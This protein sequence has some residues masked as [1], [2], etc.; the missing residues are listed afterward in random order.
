MCGIVGYI[1]SSPSQT[2]RIFYMLE[3]IK[4]RGPDDDGAVL[5]NLD[6]DAESKQH[7]FD[8]TNP[9]AFAKEYRQSCP[10]HNVALGHVRYSIVDL[11]SLG[12]QPMW[13]NC[14][15]Y[16]ISFNGEIYN[17][18]ELREELIRLG[19]IF[20][21]LTD[22]EV[23]LQAY[24]QWGPSF[25]H[26]LNGFFAFVIFD[27]KLNNLFIARDRLGVAG[28]YL[29]QTANSIQW[30]SDI[31]PLLDDPT[32]DI[33]FD[34][35]YDFIV[36][37]K[38]DRNG[39]FWS[40][41]SDF[42][43]GHYAWISQEITLKIVQFW[44]LPPTRL[45]TKDI[46][47]KDAVETMRSILIESISIRMRADVPIGFELS[48]GLDSSTIVALAAG[49]LHRNITTYTV[50]FENSGLDEE[51]YARTLADYYP[52]R[53]DYNVINPNQID[54]FW[55][56]IDY[57]LSNQEEPFH[58]PNLH[59]SMLMHQEFKSRGSNVVVSGAAGDEL[60]AGY[61]SEYLGP[62]LKY[63]LSSSKYSLCLDELLSNSEFSSLQSL[64]ALILSYFTPYDHP[65]QSNPGYKISSVLYKVLNHDFVKAT[66]NAFCLKIPGDFNEIFKYNIG[67]NLMNYWLRSGMKSAYSIPIEVRSPF[68]DFTFVDFAAILPPEYLIHSG[69]HKY[70]LRKV[71][72][73]YA[74]SSIVWRRRKMGF[75]FPLHQWLID[76]KL[77]IA[78]ITAKIH[79][80]FM[81]TKNLINHFDEIN[82][83]SPQTL[84][85]LI[86]TLLWWK[87]VVLAEA[88][89][90]V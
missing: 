68:L 81:N 51:P 34:S 31:K 63:L 6:V 5:F 89:Y 21:S 12:H 4:H 20:R 61:A 88:L 71:I 8:L 80:P 44:S 26:R 7:T 79:C 55:N 85:R 33:N 86:C 24:I 77:L 82:A 83:L 78:D 53:I 2:P 32:R 64:K 56:D 42:P 16:C 57:F 40:S 48:G 87:R 47:F 23:L 84:W 72:E 58:S 45:T 19:C 90:K 18:L 50:K 52:G 3:K 25:I 17:H 73:P 41:V 62:F 36:R 54:R 13:S 11:S 39:T 15:R 59:T 66:K 28:L 10:F 37:C 65:S 46:S 67:P 14:K 1:T 76:N 29:K 43:P 75:P 74:P 35:V 38:R 30:S 49:A 70:I 9:L 27:T 60:L 22:T 69:Y